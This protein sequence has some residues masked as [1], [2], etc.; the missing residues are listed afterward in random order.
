MTGPWLYMPFGKNILHVW[1]SKKN[2]KTWF[3]NNLCVSTSVQRTYLAPPF[4]T[5]LNTPLAKTKQRGLSVSFWSDCAD[6]HPRWFT[7]DL[8]FTPPSTFLVRLPHL[9]IK[10]QSSTTLPF[11]NKFVQIWVMPGLFPW[12]C[13]LECP[14]LFRWPIIFRGACPW[15]VRNFPA[16]NLLLNNTNTN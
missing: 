12:H 13:D 8:Q 16:I 9:M 3:G 15:S 2:W 14:W 1:N 6:H 7:S 4:W 10:S 5:I 11:T